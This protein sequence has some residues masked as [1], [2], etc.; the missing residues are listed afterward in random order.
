MYN[1]KQYRVELANNLKTRVVNF[2]ISE[3]PKIRQ[4]YVNIM[5]HKL[6][7]QDIYVTCSGS[8]NSIINF[9]G[10]VFVTN[11]NIQETQSLLQSQLKEFRFKQSRF[12]WY[13]DADEYTYFNITS[14]K[15]NE[16]VNL[17]H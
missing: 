7:E 3:F 16:L 4:A 9:T 6:W 12:R 8:N 17:F 15:D 5:A 2:Q 14:Q 10:G 13:K 11:Q 1:Q